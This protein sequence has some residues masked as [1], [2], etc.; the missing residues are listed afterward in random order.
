MQTQSSRSLYQL[1][2]GNTAQIKEIQVEG[3]MAAKLAVM[4]L[5]RGQFIT[6]KKGS[7][8]VVVEV[9]GTEVAIGRETAKKILVTAKKNTFLLAGNPNV[10]KSLIFSRLTGI[11]IISSNFPGTTVGLNYGTTQFKGDSYDI[12]D[13]PGLYRLEEEWLI[14]GKKRNLFKELDYDFIVCVADASHLERNLFFTLEIL[15]LQKPLILMLN[16]FDEAQR[17]GINI[18]V[19]KLS[20]LLGIP[21]IPTV[22]TT[23]EGLKELEREALKLANGS[24]QTPSV[25]IPSTAEE[26]WKTIGRLIQ[27]VQQVKHKHPSFW[28][29]L[30]GWATAPATGLPLA[31]ITLLVSFF[32]VRL[33]GESLINLLDPLYENYYFPFLEKVF[34]PIKDS[35]LG[36][37]LLGD[38]GENYFGVLTDGLH[39][40]LVDVMPYVLAFYTLLGFLGELGY[41]PRLAVLLDRILHKIGLHGY[42]SLPIMLGF[43]CKVP[44]VM[45]IRVLETRRERVI[46][47]AL[48]LVLAPCISQTAMI[49]SILSPY[50]IKYM[51][52]VFGALVVNG[53]VIGTLLNRLMKG[54]TPEL[55]MEIPS[56]RVPQLKPLARKIWIRMKEYFADALP[57]ILVGILFVDVMQLSGVTAWL[58]KILRAPVEWALGLPPDA[59]P[60]LLLGFLRKDVS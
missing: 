45:G 5:V 12:I 14:E 43:G 8:P 9:S 26:K 20:K 35:M 18:D 30:Q 44:A 56:W 13:I 11:G 50:G 33:V 25:E 60:L 49:I 24:T 37:L 36:L 19:K 41:L 54:E 57:L 22:A 31:F 28:E 38:G 29:H 39:I 16:K 6:R 58:T 17:K 21:V 40:A 15:Q 27:D 7:S 42:G 46:A 4:G 47:L 48:I 1:K 34:A 59:T 10:G 3:K 23:G 51:L 2:A 32:L 55:F 53:V 52:M